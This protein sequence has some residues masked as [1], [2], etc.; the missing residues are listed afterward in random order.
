M[1]ECGNFGRMSV[2]VEDI[3][4]KNGFYIGTPVGLS[5]MPLLRNRRDTVYIV[6]DK[7]LK[8]YDIV[9]YRRDSGKLV[10]HRYYGKS[11]EGLVFIGDNQ[12]VFE[13]NAR[14]EWIIGKVKHYYKDEE[15]KSLEGFGYKLYLF[16]WCK[17]FVFRLPYVLWGVLKRKIQA[18]VKG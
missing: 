14:P 3:I 10:M 16:F 17:L 13:R 12:H 6:N 15:K 8:K 7:E 18:L 5:M 2:R 4:E 1:Q 9:L 11:E